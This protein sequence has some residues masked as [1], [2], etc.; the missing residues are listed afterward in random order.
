MDSDSYAMEIYR[1]ELSDNRLYGA[2]T[3]EAE[4]RILTD[5]L[6]PDNAVRVSAKEKIIS[7]NLR[8]AV[9]MV[10]GYLNRGVPFE[11]L[12]GEANM[13]LC[14]A[15]EKFD[16]GTG[17]RFQT[18]AMWWIRDRLE[19]AVN[20]NIR[21]SQLRSPEPWR[22]D[23]NPVGIG[24]RVVSMDAPVGKGSDLTLGDLIADED[25]EIGKGLAEESMGRA[26]RD[27]VD[28][29]RETD[30]D[31]IRRRYGIGRSEQSVKDIAK[32]YGHGVKWV[33]KAEEKAL[34]RL[35]L[36]LKPHMDAEN[37]N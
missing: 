8:F 22:T 26:V 12:I 17:V 29:L 30:A 33:H 15:A 32:D 25:I 13:G 35:K 31:I 5:M 24:R 36:R 11:D 3:P 14:I 34:K 2:L 23:G 37:A 9:W 27:A 16:P 19:K 18:Y 1:R 6:G 28:D 4:R 10:G 21:I 7:H 20:A